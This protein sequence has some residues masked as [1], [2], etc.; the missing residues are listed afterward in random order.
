MT[1]IA[2]SRFVARLFALICHDDYPNDDWSDS[3]NP[4]LTFIDLIEFF[5]KAQASFLKMTSPA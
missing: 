3:A 5:S 4:E 1:P 2:V